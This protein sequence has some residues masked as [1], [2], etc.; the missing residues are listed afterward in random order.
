[1]KD[2]LREASDAQGH[3]ARTSVNGKGVLLDLSIASCRPL[4][5]DLAKAVLEFEAFLAL[6][7]PAFVTC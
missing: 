3:H 4:E 2:L 5:S 7:Q 1:V 6:K